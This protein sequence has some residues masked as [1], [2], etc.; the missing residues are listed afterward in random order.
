MSDKLDA[1]NHR[2]VYNESVGTIK[3]I[4]TIEGTN[5][6]NFLVNLEIIKVILLNKDIW[7]GVEWDD[8]TRGKHDG[9]YK[10]KRYFQ[11]K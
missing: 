8:P 4:G 2:I 1:L 6:G 11:A 3:Y 7:Y 9:L 5:E 10:Q